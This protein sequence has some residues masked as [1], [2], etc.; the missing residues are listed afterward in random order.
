MPGGVGEPSA[1]CVSVP[2]GAVV[3]ARAALGPELPSARLI[4]LL[5]KT[6]GRKTRGRS[7]P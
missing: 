5:G 2:G 1:G 4:S 6:Q 3:D 7:H